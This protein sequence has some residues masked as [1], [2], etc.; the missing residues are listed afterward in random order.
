LVTETISGVLHSKQLIKTTSNE[1]CVKFEPTKKMYD[2]M[3][4][5][6]L[7]PQN[8]NDEETKIVFNNFSNSN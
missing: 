3:T 6:V 4:Y 5:S 2:K 7:F 8:V 1:S